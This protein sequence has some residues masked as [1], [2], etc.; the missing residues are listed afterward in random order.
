MKTPP[1]RPTS[2]IFKTL[3]NLNHFPFTKGS[4]NKN[5]SHHCALKY[6]DFECDTV[7]SEEYGMP[8]IAPAIDFFLAIGC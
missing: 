2:P 4:C 3:I 7:M 6:G 8:S 5:G 1:F